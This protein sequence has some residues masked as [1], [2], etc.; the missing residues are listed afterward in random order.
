MSGL[1]M[2]ETTTYLSPEKMSGLSMGQTTYL[3]PEKYLITH[4]LT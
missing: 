3:S 2:G 1:S 4:P